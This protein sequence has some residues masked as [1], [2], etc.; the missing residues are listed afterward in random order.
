MTRRPRSIQR[1]TILKWIVENG[2]ELNTSVWFKFETAADDRE[3]VATL[4]CA[5]CSQFGERLQLMLNYRLAFVESLSNV[6]TSNFKDPADTDMH[7]YAMALLIKK[8]QSGEPC[9]YET[10]A[11]ALAESSMDAT[12]TTKITT[13]T[14]VLNI[15]Q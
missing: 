6:R 3:Q 10:I 13:T 11:K 9:E 4:R 8:A 15:Y 5:I 7:K 14:K 2:K 12:S 1:K